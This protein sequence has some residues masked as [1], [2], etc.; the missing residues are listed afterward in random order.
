MIEK[1]KNRTISSILDLK[2]G[3]EVKAEL[4]FKKEIDEIFQIRYEFES[5]INDRKYRYVCYFCKQPVKIRGKRES[6]VI[7]HFAH[8]RDSNECI[9]KTGNKLTKEE[10]QR[11]KYNGAK[12]SELHYKLK[13]QLANSLIQNNKNKGDVK[14]VFIEKVIKDQAISKVWRKP[15]VSAIFRDKRVVF[16]LQLSTT[17]LS[18]IN[19]RQEF[20]KENKTHI[21]W[22]FSSFDTDDEKRKFTQSDIFYNNNFNGFEFD[23]EAI[24]LSKNENDLVLKCYYKKLNIKDFTLNEDWQEKFV[25]LEN[26]TFDEENYS[27]Y[28][29]DYSSEKQRLTNEIENRRII[30]SSEL[31]KLIWKEKTDYEITNLIISGYKI[32]EQ[33]RNHILELYNKEILKKSVIDQYCWQFNIIWTTVLMKLQH[34]SYIERLG[35]NSHLSRII[36][37]ILGLK[38]NKIIG[39][40][41]DNQK[42]IA[43][44]VIQNRYEFLDKYLTAVKIYRPSLFTKEDK[45]GK[46]LKALKEREKTKPI[47]N[48]E[49]NDILKQIFPELFIKN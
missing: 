13:M 9:I 32:K 41:L 42:Q 43:N 28:Y 17:F 27:I 44:L 36:L 21:L 34:T 6:K 29:Y 30:N 35:K 33:E 16:E 47:Q 18:V 10:I 19:S 45:K 1:E 40:S 23:K 2:S 5:S 12:E 7:M 26:L 39:Y 3:G 11:I 31:I 48:T 14:D 49:E 46:L 8:L 22:V 38:L 24:D 25:K 20:Y 4:F 37:D 15:D